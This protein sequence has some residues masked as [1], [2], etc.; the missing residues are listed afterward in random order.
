MPWLPLSHIYLTHRHAQTHARGYGAGART[1]TRTCIFEK[2]GEKNHKVQKG[3]Q[4]GSSSSPSLLF[5]PRYFSPAPTTFYRFPNLLP[6][7]LCIYVYEFLLPTLLHPRLRW[8]RLFKSV[9]GRPCPCAW[10]SVTPEYA[11]R[12]AARGQAKQDRTGKSCSPNHTLIQ[13]WSLLFRSLPSALCTKKAHRAPLPST[14]THTHEH[15]YR[16][17]ESFHEEW[18]VRLLLWVRGPFFLYYILSTVSSTSWNFSL[19]LQ[20]VSYGATTAHHIRSRKSWHELGNQ[21][22]ERV[23]VCMCVFLLCFSTF[24]SS[25]P[26]PH[27]TIPLDLFPLNGS[28]SGGGG[29]GASSLSFICL[30]HFSFSWHL[31]CLLFVLAGYFT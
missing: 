10:L 14:V 20:H 5:P 13:T 15:C 21:E 27:H 17:R 1:H 11:E 7:C 24:G 2:E 3:K 4:S 6:P 9:P 31:F 18:G 19:P 8:Q 26:I 28:G 22:R 25:S 30:F 12:R 29:A 23:C 16:E